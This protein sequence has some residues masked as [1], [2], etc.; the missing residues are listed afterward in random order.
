MRS[1]CYGSSLFRAFRY[2]GKGAKNRATA[3]EA[4]ERKRGKKGQ[5]TGAFPS[6]RPSPLSE[7]L[8]Q[9]T[10]DQIITL[11]SQMS[12]IVQYALSPTL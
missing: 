7:R 9:A 4:S 2:V 8:G 3:R 1:F 6:S 5:T 12:H 10:I 11:K